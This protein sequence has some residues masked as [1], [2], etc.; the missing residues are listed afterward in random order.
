MEDLH[1]QD[2]TPLLVETL[3]DCSSY[4]YNLELNYFKRWLEDSLNMAIRGSAW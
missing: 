3:D 4:R 2:A 1:E